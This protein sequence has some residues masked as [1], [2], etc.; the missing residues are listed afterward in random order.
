MDKG[1]PKVT[2][3]DVA[4]AAGVS[5]ATVSYV[6]RNQQG[7]SQE[8][9]ARV[10]QISEQLGYI[11]DAR[12]VSRMATIRDAG[13][14][15]LVPIAWVDT[16]WEKDSWQIYK[17]LS[18]YIEG[19]RARA[20]QL[21]Y[22]IEPI[23]AGQPGMTMKRVSQIVY[24]RGIEG[25]IVT[26]G[27]SHIR[28][29]W[30]KLAAVT[31]EGSVLAPRLHRITTDHTFNLLLA[32]KMMKRHGYRRIGICLDQ[33]VGRGSYNM[34]RA[35]VHY[36]HGTLPSAEI[37]PPL[38][39]ER[40]RANFTWEEDR[41][42]EKSDK[43]ILAWMRK[44]R[45]DAVACHDAHLVRALERGGYRVPE[46]VGVAHIATDDDVTDWAGVNSKRREIGAAAAGLVISLLQNG[47]FGVPETAF[48]TNIRG[49]WHGGRTLLI[50]KPR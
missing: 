16:N 45:P 41:N 9:R 18:P 22:R 24:Q 39:L 36:F 32:L 26:H 8:T 1:K 23:W 47:Q 31:L 20:Q 4:K 21:G 43:L 19:A 15:E 38:Y 28:L 13:A 17:F 49:T 33:L 5:K 11:P 7:P 42:R 6:L 14:K 46:E 48:N 35:A 37:V 30:D 3:G 10:L 27:A 29:N 40:H 12:L 50:P 25:V 34:C 2:V 44:H